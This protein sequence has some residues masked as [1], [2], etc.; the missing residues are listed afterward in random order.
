[1]PISGSRISRVGEGAAVV[2]PT[3]ESNFYEQESQK[4]AI[5]EKGKQKRESDIYGDLGKVKIEGIFHKHQP[6]FA[7]KQ[8]KLYDYVKANIDDLR[9][10]D[11]TK[12][13]EYQNMLTKLGSDIGLSK[14]TAINYKDL[15]TT[16]I[17]D[18]DKYDD[19]IIDKL[20]DFEG[21]DKE[22]DQFDVPDQAWLQE[23][24][25]LGADAKT[26]LVPLFEKIKEEGQTS[27][28]M[29]DGSVRTV[30]TEELTEDDI[31]SVAVNYRLNDPRI[32]GQAY[33]NYKKEFN[34]EP[35]DEQLKDYYFN[36]YGKDF[37][38]KRQFVTR[39][40]G[41]SDDGSGDSEI[42]I[43]SIKKQVPVNIVEGGNEVMDGK[44]VQ[45]GKKVQD[46]AHYGVTL[47]SNVTLDIP[48]SKNVIDRQTGAALNYTGQLNIAGGQLL[49]TK[50]GTQKSGF[51]YV[52]YLYTQATVKDEKGNPKKV[53]VQ[54]P[55]SEIRGQKVI[56]KS[57]PAINEFERLTEELNKKETPKKDN[58]SAELRK[59]YNY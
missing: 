58:K 13:I 22:T 29:A 57:A 37:V 9:R 34:E 40:K 59:K 47:P 5:R 39:T 12:T 23:R 46:V 48:A 36:K 33:R 2:F 44:L 49:S 25:D 42:N 14:A 52:P 1:M 19:D 53:D 21:Y 26:N 6:V 31:K 3:T 18:Q 10:G 55:L 50:V 54:I 16:Y 11:A 43:E 24:V 56:E 8:K 45:T 51:K 35:S 15:F 4:N 20:H 30:K 38:M 28:P 41:D 27:I 17:K 32:R 7:E